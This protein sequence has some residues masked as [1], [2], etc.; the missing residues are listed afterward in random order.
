[1]KFLSRNFNFII[2]GYALILLI[3]GLG[4]LINF[5]ILPVFIE[6]IRVNLISSI[7]H[8]NIPFSYRNFDTTDTS[9][10]NYVFGILSM[11][12]GWHNNHHKNERELVNSHYWWE[13]DVEGLIGKLLSYDDSK[14][15]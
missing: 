1:M 5:F 4:S 6:H 2:Y 7:S 11:G 9:Q 3:F 14:S 13:I 15:C 12:F 8:L 10:N